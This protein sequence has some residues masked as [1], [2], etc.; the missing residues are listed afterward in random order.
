MTTP[1]P[2]TEN[3]DIRTY[4]DEAGVERWV[5]GNI[6]VSQNNAFR[7]ANDGQPLVYLQQ[8]EYRRQQANK[9]SRVVDRRR[10]QG[11]DGSILSG[12]SNKAD[13][14]LLTNNQLPQHWAVR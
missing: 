14:R 5:D 3:N 11:I 13:Q 12:M 10:R 7:R 8:M 9:T 2:D 1:S 6:P 4:I